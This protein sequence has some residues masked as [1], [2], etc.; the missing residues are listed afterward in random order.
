[1]ARNLANSDT[2]SDTDET[3]TPDAGATR[4][5]ATV[6]NRASV[7][8]KAKNKGGTVVEMTIEVPFPADL[9]EAAAVYGP[10]TAYAL[11]D[12][13]FDLI[14]QAKMRQMVAA[15]KTA[16][17]I[18]AAFATFVPTPGK[19]GPRVSPVEKAKSAIAGLSSE[20]RAELLRE[21]G[22]A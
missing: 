8:V 14:V 17:E 10:S 11:I 19:R 16:E 9:D 1:M 2:A 7:S 18:T 21:L 20:A 4:G 5:I 3:G 12:R 6:T 15:D 13:A 22:L